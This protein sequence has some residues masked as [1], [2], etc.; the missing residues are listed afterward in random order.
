VLENGQL[1]EEGSF[2]ELMEKKGRFYQLALRQM[3]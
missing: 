2:K 1:I 3:T